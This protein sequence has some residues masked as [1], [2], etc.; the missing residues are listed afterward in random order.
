M[1]ARSDKPEEVKVAAD[2]TKIDAIDDEDEEEGVGLN[3][4]GIKADFEGFL[5]KKGDKGMIKMWAKRYFRFYQSE[6]L[7]CYFKNDKTFTA[8][9][10]FNLNGALLVEKSN[11]KA[12]AFNITMKVSARVWRL[13]AKDESTRTAW[14]DKIQ[15]FFKVYQ[16]PAPAAAVDAA[17]PA[18]K[19]KGLT[20]Q[21]LTTVQF[22]TPVEQSLSS[23]HDPLQDQSLG[24]P[25]FAPGD[26]HLFLHGDGSAYVQEVVKAELDDENSTW[27]RGLPR[28]LKDTEFTI[29]VKSLTDP[30]V[31]VDQQQFHL[32]EKNEQELLRKLIG[33]QIEVSV[34]RD[35]KFDEPLKFEGV[36]VYDP[37]STSFGL[38]NGKSNTVHFLNTQEGISYALQD[39][40]QKNGLL[41]AGGSNGELFHDASLHCQ[42]TSTAE[43]SHNLELTYTLKDSFEWGV[44]YVGVLDYHESEMELSGWYH[45]KN[46]SGRTFQKASITLMKNPKEEAEKKKEEAKEG[47]DS[48]EEKAAE[49][50]KEKGKSMFGGL[51]SLASLVGGSSEE[52]KPPKPRIYKY[53]VSQQSTLTDDQTRQ[54][55]LI[56][57]KIPIRSM[58]VVSWEMPLYAKKPHVG[59]DAGTTVTPQIR[60]VV[61]FDNK[62]DIG[63][64]LPLPAGPISLV[65]R[66]KNGF[67]VQNLA[68][69]GIGDMVPGDIIT[70]PVEDFEHV[71]ATRKQIGFNLDADKLFIIEQVEITIVNGRQEAAEIVIEESLFRWH[72]HEITASSIPW[73]Q[74]VHPHKIFFKVRLGALEDIT[75]TYTVFYNQFTLD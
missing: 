22:S 14:L 29:A 43:K 75:F 30:A 50:A 65:R 38:F 53:Y 64:G 48:V 63:L 9:G 31:H 69:A 35:K 23:R 28:T 54:I 17:K 61:E 4:E 57:T 24:N 21:P 36:V 34:P 10:S 72:S 37:K 18:R 51:G 33:H 52:A 39:N 71:T 74:H 7:I 66:E 40:G 56:H 44:K 3:R 11:E 58:D 1:S 26:V 49:V 20:F 59:Q 2:P 16:S 70:L 25:A 41:S 42:F 32:D 15:P 27:V 68:T 6:G 19:K 60:T 5:D 8:T 62:P 46:K 47:E 13:N 67:G 55:R 45:I 73:H 12:F